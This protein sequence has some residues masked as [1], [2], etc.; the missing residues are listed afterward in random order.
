MTAP[1][2]TGL[3]SLMS[4]YE[5]TRQLSERL[6]SVYSEA[7]QTIQSMPDA[8]PVKWHLAHTSW[9]FETFLLKP[10]L[11]NYRVFHPSYEYLFNSYYNSVGDQYYRPNRG[12]ISRP[13]K[14]EVLAYRQ[15]VDLGMAELLAT[16]E[17]DDRKD[18]Q[19]LVQLGLAHE[20]QH[21]EL[22]VT[23]IQHALSFNPMHPVITKAPDLFPE[24]TEL[25]WISIGEDLYEIGSDTAGFCFDNE[26]P[27][28]KVYVHS[29]SAANRLTTNREYIAFIESGG[30][31]DPLLW[32]SEGW[33]WKSEQQIRAPLYWKSQDGEWWH[34]SL[35][36]YHPVDLNAPVTHVS[37]FE[38]TAFAQWAGYRLLTEF[39]WEV[40][41]R[42]H[43]NIHEQYD[44]G[45]L[46]PQPLKNAND[47]IQLFNQLWQWTGSQYL[48]YPGF[49]IP[50]GAVG[51]YNGKFMSNQF[52]LRGGSCVTPPMH[53]RATYRNFFP[54]TARWQY[55]GIR[56][57]HDG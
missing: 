12:L 22:L 15:R 17:F 34:Y 18:L 48:P 23:D 13:G 1:L 24:A 49:K 38:A 16:L 28:H 37:Y 41:A 2:R 31:D 4:P 46:R 25:Q 21:Q 27:K 19:T 10:N 47:D 32:L 53:I 55:S 7:D 29:F 5:Q 26:T 54:A 42:L 9:F 33:A 6:A 30:Y 11:E 36:G 39:E 8:S 14:E 40:L 45:I 43:P 3:S 44:P 50:Q 56:I 35:S 51:E 20:Q 57:A 52:V